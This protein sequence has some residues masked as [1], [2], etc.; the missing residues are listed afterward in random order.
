MPFETVEIKVDYKAAGL[1][2]E[3]CRAVLDCYTNTQNEEMGRR[4]RRALL[5]CPG[6]GYDWCSE[7]EAEPI[8]FRFLGYD[9]N[10]F[11]LRYSCVKKRFPTAALECAAAVKYI[12]ENAERLDIDP[13]KI[14]VAGFSAGGHLAAS[15]ANFWNSALLCTPLGCQP[16]DIKPNGSLLCYPVLTSKKEFT[17]EGTI[18]NIIG[19]DQS[20]E[21]RLMVS[22]ED[23]VGPHTPPTF[24]WHCA[25]DGCV[26]VENSLFYMKALSKNKIP[27][28]CHIY[29]WG[30]H[31]LSLCDSSTA[32]WEGHNQPVAADWARL[33]VEWASRL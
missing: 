25:D 28:E 14:I 24:L 29:E 33:A 3:G 23:R 6:G 30:G 4:R 11:V 10:C 2:P 5:I 13:D 31:G 20:E 19:E 15:L 22:L 17:H 18:Q 26:P 16:E 1:D 21:L 7:R 9:F 8:A 12:R 27:F 32:T